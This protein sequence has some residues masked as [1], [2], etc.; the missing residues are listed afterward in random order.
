[1]S[2]ESQFDAQHQGVRAIAAAAGAAGVPQ[3][4]VLGQPSRVRIAGEPGT[5]SSSTIGLKQPFEPPVQ[6]GSFDNL[7][8]AKPGYRQCPIKI[9]GACTLS[10]QPFPYADIWAP[11]ERIFNA[12]GL[13]RCLWGTDWTRA[14]CLLTYRQAVN[15]F[16]VT[17]HLSDSDRV[18]L[19]GGS[20]AEIYRWSPGPSATE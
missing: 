2:Y 18:T 9:T 15:A 3:Y 13:H 12:F 8:A 19:M 1:M 16:R 20:V 7:D 14:T 10:T 5:Q 4:F 11:L 17:E 6:P